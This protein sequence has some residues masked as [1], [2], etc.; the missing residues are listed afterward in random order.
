M[1][2]RPYLSWTQLDTLERSEKK[3][4]DIYI[5]DGPRFSNAAMGFGKRMDDVIENDETTGDPVLDLVSLAVPTY[6]DQQHEILTELNGVPLFGKLDDFK[7]ETKDAFRER[8]TGIQ[9]WT[10]KKVDIFG[11]ITF[12]YSMIYAE[13]GIKPE[14][15]GCELVYIPTKRDESG[16][17]E[18]VGDVRIFKTERTMIDILEMSNRQKKAWER[19][20]ELSIQ[21]VV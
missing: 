16:D 4:I 17:I 11:Q 15:V 5:E 13:Y 21:S 7:V 1:T 18:P 19:I 10:Q 12:Y 8:K 6:S 14:D 3:Y 20:K 9:L 2:P